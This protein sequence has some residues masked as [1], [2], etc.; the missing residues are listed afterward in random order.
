MAWLRQTAARFRALFRAPELDRELDAE[1]TSHLEFAVEEN[2][3]RGLSPDEA[4]RQALRHFGGTQQARESQR[5]ARAFPKLESV[6]RD[7]RFGARLLLRDRTFTVMAVL[8]LA[9]GIGANTAIFSVVSA[10][11]LQPLPYRDADRL[12]IVWEQN[13]HR[14]WYENNVSAANFLDWKKQ[15]HVFSDLAA[16]E[17]DSFELTGESH[18]EEVSGERV[19]TNLFSLLGVQPFRG[20]LFLPEMEKKGSAGVLL[21]YGLW[22]ERYGADPAIVGKPITVDG[23]PVTVVGILPVSFS[24]DYSAS[25]AGRSRLWVSGLDLHDE[26]REFHNYSA[27]G[28]LKPQ[29]SVA[30]AQAEMDIIARRIEEQ[31]PDSRGWQVALV[32]LHDQAVEQARPA[33]LVLLCAVGLVLLIACAN[34]ANLLLV[35]ATKREREIAVRCALGAGRGRIVRQLL[36]ESTLVSFLGGSLGLVLAAWASGILTSMFPPET[37]G[38]SRAGINVAVLLFAATVALTTGISFGMVPALEASKTNLN[39]TLKEGGRGSDKAAK[40]KVL[41]D[42][43]VVSEFALALT[44]LFGAGLMIHTL[45]HLARV[46]L[47]F[48]P[49]G[50]MAIKVPLQGPQ[51]DRDQQKQARFYQQ[52]IARVQALPGVEAASVARGV[53]MDDWAGWDFVTADNPRPPAGEVPDAN[54]VVVGPDYFRTLGIP[55]RAGRPFS[56]NDTATTE[57]RAIVSQ[58]LADKYWSGQNPI[59]KRLKIGSDPA[60]KNLPWLSVVGVVG[61]VKSQGQVA[62]FVPEIYVPYTQFPWIL[63]PRHIV[64]R[65]TAAS[66]SAIVRAIR[67]EV[68]NLDKE[69]PV[70]DVTSLGEIVARRVRPNQT[71]MFLLGSF[72]ALALVLA[73]IG[74]YSVISYAVSERTHEIG[75]RMALGAD[76]PTVTRMVV[77]HGLRLTAI[78]VAAGL[79][80]AFLIT[81]LLSGLP[82]EARAPLLFDVRPL[83]PLTLL[84]VSA[85]LVVVALIACYIP[86]R[87]ATRVPP[88]VALRYE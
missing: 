65:T 78:G 35:R 83:D 53:P 51:Y 13:P 76:R 45:V 62:P 50:V 59:G 22:Q 48:N 38:I 31:Y 70:A 58:S 72:A 52:L 2:L 8:M 25:F 24:N 30:E 63:H 42:L 11:L 36:I 17:S 28:K 47:G 64:L 43:L 74:I 80:G 19:T 71:V 84:G 85:L 67:E 12:V 23:Q 27:I 60:D 34:V 41:R 14:G 26:G 66:P 40:R 73:A 87:R 37:L 49:A 46:E 29:V 3:A 16:F 79:V 77:K 75:I 56:E 69:V 81:R 32:Q 20:G 55:L 4:R 54:Y 68:A 39:E 57:P 9:L 61:N 86:A 5:E 33:L 6:L 7:L 82:V 18:P 88:T 1:M 44:L 10:V 15:N 21:S